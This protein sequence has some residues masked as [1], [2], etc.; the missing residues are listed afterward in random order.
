MAGAAGKGGSSRKST[1]GK[2]PR[3]KLPSPPPDSE[4]ELTNGKTWKAPHF[5][6]SKTAEVD[7]ARSDEAGSR[8]AWFDKEP[9]AFVRC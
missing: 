9:A 2:A 8:P 6:K 7:D 5:L 3:V 1:G 4:D